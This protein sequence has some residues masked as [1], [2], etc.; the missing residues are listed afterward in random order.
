MTAKLSKSFYRSEF[1]CKCGKCG[2]D[3]IDYELIGV[4][5][6]LDGAIV[7]Y[8]SGEEIYIV[9]S[10]GNRCPEHNED[11]GGSEGS[12]H[13]YFIACDFKVYVTGTGRQIPPDVIHAILDAAFPNKYGLGRYYNRNHL[14][15]RAARA[16]WAA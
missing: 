4:L 16:R 12:K 15:V 10:S 1:A 5:E 14:D 11:E 8:L 6:W 3:A 13:Q 2:R 9:I 7:H